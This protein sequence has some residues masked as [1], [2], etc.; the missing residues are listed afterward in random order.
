MQGLLAYP[1]CSCPSLA[2]HLSI[3][4][5]FTVFCNLWHCHSNPLILWLRDHQ[6]VRSHLHSSPPVWTAIRDPS[7]QALQYFAI[8]SRGL[9]LAPM[10]VSFSHAGS[11]HT[12][13]GLAIGA[14]TS[15][16]VTYS[17]YI[18]YK[19]IKNLPRQVVPPSKFTLL[20]RHAILKVEAHVC[21]LLLASHPCACGDV[22]A[23]LGIAP[24][25]SSLSLLGWLWQLLWPDAA[26]SPLFQRRHVRSLWKAFWQTLCILL[27]LF[28]VPKTCSSSYWRA[29]FWP[30]NKPVQSRE[31]GVW[32]ESSLRN[33]HQK[34]H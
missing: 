30:T 14:D 4:V 10:Q 34:P 26:L 29:A 27:A 19:H 28:C 31:V 23:A 7:C 9:W 21:A 15:V 18:V 1:R 20:H 11:V 2:S 3:F 25:C 16:S 33:T 13:T 8:L 22:C 6:T 24:L 12:T 17:F 5:C 32:R